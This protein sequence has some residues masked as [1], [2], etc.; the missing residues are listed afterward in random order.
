MHVRQKHILEIRPRKLAAL[1]LLLVTHPNRQ[2]HPRSLGGPL[3]TLAFQGHG[4][5]GKNGRSTSVSGDLQRPA[6]DTHPNAVDAPGN[7]V[8]SVKH[9]PFDWRFE[10][11][12]AP[13]A[14]S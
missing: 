2:I 6:S 4:A 8:T 1:A 7:A 9:T 12:C 10:D 11:V 14:A 3:K 5:D 13:R